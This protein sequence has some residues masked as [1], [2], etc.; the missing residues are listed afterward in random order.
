M[1]STW[2]GMTDGTTDASSALMPLACATISP[3]NPLAPR[4]AP[5][6][7]PRPGRGCCL[8]LLREGATP[9]G[10]YELPGSC[11]LCC[12]CCWEGVCGWSGT[13]AR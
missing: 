11:C 10:A 6:Q 7:R 4:L 5:S 9:P 1:L 13:V 2:A 8:P 12:C 3:S